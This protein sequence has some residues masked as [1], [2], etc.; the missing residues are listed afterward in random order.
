[1]AKPTDGRRKIKYSKHGRRTKWA[2]FW[3]VVKKYGKGKKVHPSMMT[4][5][6]RSRRRT[7]LRIKPFRQRRQHLG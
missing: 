5:N 7:K 1:M 4:S 6:K 3:A 2:P